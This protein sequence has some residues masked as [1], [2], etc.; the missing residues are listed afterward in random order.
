[1]SHQKPE[2]KKNPPE[3]ENQESGQERR[4]L[5]PEELEEAKKAAEGPPREF[6]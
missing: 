2:E 5:K 4:K 1:M 3:A 6:R